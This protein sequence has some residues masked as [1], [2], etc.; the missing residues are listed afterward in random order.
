[1][2]I[3]LSLYFFLLPSPSCKQWFCARLS[4]QFCF[5]YSPVLGLLQAV[6]LQELLTL[7]CPVAFAFKTELCI[8]C[9]AQLAV[10][11]MD[12]ESSNMGSATI[13]ENVIEDF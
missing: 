6:D 7:G 11:C 10:M 9:T 4:L 2:A 13:S 8:S 3:N 12:V 5:P 1:M